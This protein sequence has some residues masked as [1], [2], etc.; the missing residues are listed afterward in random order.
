MKNVILITG[1]TRG[2]G[3]AIADI[4]DGPDTILFLTGTDTSKV[5][6]MNKT[7]LHNRRYLDVNFLDLES[8]NKFISFIKGLDRLDVCVNNAGINIIK[9]IEEV[10]QSDFENLYTVN[11]KAP[12]LICQAAASIMRKHNW[13]RIV[14]IASIWSTITK[15]GRSL[16]TGS[17]AAL[18]GM[19]R[20]MAVE[21]AP[22]NVLVNCVSPGFTL[23]DL[24]QYSLSDVE[25][26]IIVSKIPQAR[27]AK[28][29]EIAKVVHFLC[30]KDNT[31]LTGQNIVVDGGFSIV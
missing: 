6:A 24:T 30:S 15:A 4:F 1:A 23:T 19:T 9:P 5:A 2:I 8:L 11:L 3:A 17:K 29:T 26:E 31:Y 10:S 18:V 20:T 28:P 27:M 21:L 7:A 14:N 16:Y 12:Y 13:G 22:D 25:I